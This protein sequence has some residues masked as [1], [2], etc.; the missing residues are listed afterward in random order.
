MPLHL[1]LASLERALAHALDVGDT[2]VLPPAFEFRAIKHSPT[3]LQDLAAKDMF[4]WTISPPRRAIAPKQALGF[5]P[6]MQ[7]DP[8]DLL[9]T[10]AL[11]IEIS[12]DIEL[13]RVPVETNVI[14]SFRYD[15]SSSPNL[16]RAEFTFQSFRRAIREELDCDTYS[17]IVVTDI[18]DFFP[19][20]YHHRLQ[21]N[22]EQMTSNHDHIR[23][24]LRILGQFTDRDSHGIPVG[25]AFSRILAEATLS[26]IDD[27]L[28][29]DNL[30]F[31]RYADDFVIFCK[32][33]K[34]AHDSLATLAE[35]LYESHG[36]TLNAAKTRIVEC[37]SYYGEAFS[38]QDEEAEREHLEDSWESI[39]ESLGIEERYGA[40][41]WDDLDEETQQAITS[42]NLG[43][44]L[45][46]KLQ[47][48]E[49]DL[50]F[51]RFL[52]NRLTQLKDSDNLSLV[53]DNLGKLH[54]LFSS[55]IRW[56]ASLDNVSGI[57]CSKI[58]KKI[59]DSP[60]TAPELN[61][62]FHRIWA[63][64]LIS[65]NSHWNNIR[66][67]QAALNS[68][69]DSDV[70]R[71]I[72]TALGAAGSTAWFRTNRRDALNLSPWE[73]RAFLFGSR[74]MNPDERK[75]WFRA[76]RPR[77]QELDSIVMDWVEAG[78]P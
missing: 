38:S 8:L 1:K 21:N 66:Q 22:L 67:T 23:A 36:L 12:N 48:D 63:Y 33:K 75:H 70:R 16:Y 60:N 9:V 24:L 58:A 26:D 64:Y 28:L 37:T 54:V 15:N 65:S 39:L 13:A 74:A 62:P 55:V 47:E 40:I 11:V 50:S 45:F 41:E 69:T 17:H 42:L 59:L 35:Q 14:H 20:I 61:L 43:E 7:L 31:L 77:V 52:I 56:M 76:I 29:S 44:I 49:V 53:V 32:S 57:D 6:V 34:Q 10:T 3:A 5:R 2:D 73:R 71:E 30:R 27:L 51:L 46:T 19:R 25:P 4:Q 78:C 72:I 18:S 68:E